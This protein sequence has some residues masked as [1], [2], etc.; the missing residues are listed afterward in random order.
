MSNIFTSFGF[1]VDTDALR[2]MRADRG[3]TRKA[4]ANLAG[5]SEK[6]YGLIEDGK[7]IPR[8]SSLS[9]IASA[10]GVSN[11]SLLSVKNAP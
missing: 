7:R 9:K 6:T 11:S 1:E 2:K 4:L 3:F 5:V 10:L 8:L